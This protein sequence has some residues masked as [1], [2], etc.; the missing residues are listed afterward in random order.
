MQPQALKKEMIKNLPSSFSASILFLEEI[1]NLQ[2]KKEIVVKDKNKLHW[3][4]PFLDEWGLHS[5]GG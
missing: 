4:N 1:Q 3:L 2:C 5:V